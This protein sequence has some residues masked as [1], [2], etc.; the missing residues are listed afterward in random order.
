MGVMDFIGDER[1]QIKS[2]PNPEMKCYMDGDNI[3]LPDGLHISYEGWFVVRDKKIVQIGKEVYDKWGGELNLE[4]IID[5]NNPII[6]HLK[7]IEELDK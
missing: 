1:I 7:A 5:P 6:H 4:R 3:D 2:T